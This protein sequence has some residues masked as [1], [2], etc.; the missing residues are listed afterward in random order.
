MGGARTTE[1]AMNDDT[2]NLDGGPGPG[3]ATLTDRLSDRE[4]QVLAHYAQG[5]TYFQIGRRL[6]ITRHTVDTYVRRVRAKTGVTTGAGLVRLGLG[7]TGRTGP[8]R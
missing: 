8:D 1:T 2:T 4:R 6:G 5:F 3:T 7:L